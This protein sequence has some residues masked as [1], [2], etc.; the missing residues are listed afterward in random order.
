MNEQKV[1]L[2]SQLREIYGRIVY[3][4]KTHEKCADI[5]KSRSDCIKNV[6]IILSA[7]TTTS[8]LAISLGNGF[9]FQF[10]AAICATA[11]LGLALY[12]K[13]NN[14]LA[15]VEKHKHAALD[16]LEIREKFF[17]LLV[18]IKIDN[19]E[20]A[21]FQ[22]R[23]DELNEHLTN[24]YKGAPKTLTSAYTLASKALKEKEEFTFSDAE[25]DKF[26]PESLRKK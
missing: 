11:T 19:K 15:I 25:I 5:L 1:L 26:L 12:S 2:E 6:E 8:I 3:T 23:R 7:F 21:Y 10:I 13:E 22:Q 16:I 9:V 18:D 4:H 24:T 20:I 14:L 17:S